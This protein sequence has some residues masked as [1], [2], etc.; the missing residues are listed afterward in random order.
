MQDADFT[1]RVSA[2]KHGKSMVVYAWVMWQMYRMERRYEE[3]FYFSYTADLAADHIKM[4]NRFIQCNSHFRDWTK[5]TSGETTIK[6]ARGTGETRQEFNVE[7]KGIIEA[8]RGGHPHWVI[9]DDILKDPENEMDISQI[10]KVGEAF[11]N[12]V[13][14]LPKEGGKIHVTGTKQDEADLFA[15][16]E[17]DPTFKSYSDPAFVNEAS[18]ITLWEEVFP[19]SRLDAIRSSV[20][21]KAFQREYMCIPVRSSNAFF[22][23][24]E[25]IVVV[26]KELINYPLDMPR[27]TSNMYEIRAGF[28]I[29]KKQHPSHLSVLEKR[30]QQ[31]IQIV[32]F[33]M[34]GWAYTK[35]IEWL[36]LAIKNLKIDV[37]LYDNTRGEFELSEEI[38][39]LPPEMIP[40]VFTKKLKHSAATEFEK[41]VQAGQSKLQLLEDPR[42]FR[43]ILNC[44]NDLQSVETPEG[45]G[46]AFWSNA[47]ALYSFAEP[48]PRIRTL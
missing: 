36:K 11:R 3:G 20:G 13:M 15:D 41:K 30:E 43:S 2:R 12:R 18:G 29:G 1:S 9:C 16:L 40:A 4:I 34:D 25:L 8:V 46:D 17:K 10:L 28:D 45:H 5:Q 22:G 24:Q 6:Y 23:R 37:V 44:D 31:I 21:N 42:Q 14:S 35:Q 27:E 48:E 26:N 32:S 19:A 39:D 7:P 47:L 33:W 38:G